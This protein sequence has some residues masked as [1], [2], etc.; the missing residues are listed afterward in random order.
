MLVGR[1]VVADHVQ[2]D[3]GVGAGLSFTEISGV[4]SRNYLA[5]TSGE[6]P[7]CQG[8]WSTRIQIGRAEAA[9]SAAGRV[10]SR[11]LRQIIP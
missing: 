2:L 8:S 7:L 3:A 9:V 6:C 4:V 5:Q 11:G 1:V 10:A